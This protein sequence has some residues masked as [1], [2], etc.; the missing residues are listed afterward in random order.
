VLASILNINWLDWMVLGIYLAVVF[1]FGLYMAR[2]EDSTEDFF[3]AGRRLPWYAIALSLFATNISSGSLIGLSGDA[4]RV[5]LAVGTLE[6]GAILGLLLLAFVFLPYY[7][8]RAVYT[9]PEFM[10]HRYN[11]TVRIL[12][13]GIVLLFEI[14]VNIPFVLYAG[15]LALKVTFGVP[16]EWAIV[17]IGVFVGVYTTIGGLGAVVW[18]DVIQGVLMIIGGTVLTLFGLHA[19]GGIEGLTTHAA[20]KLHVC[21][22]GDHPDYP[23]PATMIG[24]YFLVTIY[25]WCQNQTMVQRTLGARSEWDA[26]MGAMAACFIKL[27][28]PFIIVLP[29][30][31]AFVLFPELDSSDKALPVLIKSVIPAG[32]SGLLVATV[33]ASLMS[34]ADSALNSWATIF[35]HDFYHRL[36]NR[37][38]SPKRLILI[39]RLA[40]VF[41]LIVTVVRTT[42]LGNPE[43]ILQFLL[44]GLGYI[45]C[46]IIVIFMVGIFWSRATS[47]AAIVTLVTSPVVCYTTQHM[48]ETFG[49]GFSQTS[50][51]YWLPV[52]V[53]IAVL[54]MIIVSLATR[55]KPR[56]A[57]QNLIWSRQD[58]MTMGLHL[59]T[60]PGDDP[61]PS[62]PHSKEKWSLWADY[63]IIGVTA[64]I[65]MIVIIWLLR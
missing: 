39:G 24:G 26:R 8:K 42:L 55:P 12:F 47:T 19:I 31:I 36:I 21:L 48:K 33:I 14:L 51:V 37:K 9:M 65:L 45:S 59:F 32:L 53:G 6:W 28:L 52:A 7:Q 23:F 1:G 56:E 44:N 43:S 25:Y 4:Y 40:I 5:G 16:E 61:S 58:T 10:E 64:L 3:L 29:G 35:T 22:P 60:R 54:I 18:T 17:L 34:S 13:A 49:W 38:A 62:P 15:G 57:L 27:I 30:V 20:D 50:I 63:R 46:P 11:L 41:V 2:K